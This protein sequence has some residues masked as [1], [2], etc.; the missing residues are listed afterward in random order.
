VC[1]TSAAA[2]AAALVKQACG[3]LSPAQVRSIL[4]TTAKD[5]TT[6]HCNSSTGGAAATVGPDTATGNGLVDAEKAVLKAKLQCNVIVPIQPIHPIQPIQPIQ[7]VQPVLPIQPVHPIQPVLPIQPIQPIR[8]GQSGPQNVSVFPVRPVRPVQPIVPIRPI[9][10]IR[11]IEPIRPIRPIR[12]ID[13]GP[14]AATEAYHQQ[15]ATEGGTRRG[16][17][18]TAEEL[19]SLEDM[20]SRGEIGLEDL[21]S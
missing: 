17:S 6:G 2:G 21:E 15:G 14:L 18:F 13:P 20:A 8:P 12:P 5:V 7:P 9:R 19:K 4:M 10:P 11:P 16:Q 3:H 1:P